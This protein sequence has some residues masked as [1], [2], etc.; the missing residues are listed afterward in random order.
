[1]AFVSQIKK[2]ID[3]QN[4]LAQKASEF[5]AEMTPL[6]GAVINIR[7]RSREAATNLED[8][9]EALHK[10]AVEQDN[11]AKK[12]ADEEKAIDRVIEVKKKQLAL[13][14]DIALERLKKEHAA[15]D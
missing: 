12:L 13:E 2:Q 15:G 6:V 3:A 14:K 5:N 10:I 9:A 11:A 7:D 4:E 1:A 8:M